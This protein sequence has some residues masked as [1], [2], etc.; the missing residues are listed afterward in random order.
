MNK[1]G[2]TLIELLACVII[3][4]FIV[5]IAVPEVQKAVKKIKLDLFKDNVN[6]LLKVARQQQLEDGSL[7]TITYTINNSNIDPSLS[8]NKKFKGA[9][10]LEIDPDGKTSLQIELNKM[11]AKKEKTDSIVTVYSTKCNEI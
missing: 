4:G 9:G 8:F 5:A 7:D 10:T 11:C 1:K 2:F 6:E 3:L